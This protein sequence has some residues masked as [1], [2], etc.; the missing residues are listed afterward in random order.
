MGCGCTMLQQKRAKL[1][2]NG[3]NRAGRQTITAI[4]PLDEMK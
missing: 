4:E 1:R 2:T 3:A